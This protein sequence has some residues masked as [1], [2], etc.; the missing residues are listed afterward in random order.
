MMVIITN[1]SLL[2]EKFLIWTMRWLWTDSFRKLFCITHPSP[3]RCAWDAASCCFPTLDCMGVIYSE[4]I[5]TSATRKDITAALFLFVPWS[6][7][8]FLTRLA[9]SWF[10]VLRLHL[11]YAIGFEQMSC[12]FDHTIQPEYSNMYKR[13]MDEN[14]NTPHKPQFNSTTSGSGLEKDQEICVWFLIIS[15]HFYFRVSKERA[16]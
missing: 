13:A 15:W 10:S 12:R 9:G 5:F 6:R 16:T 3:M 14:K 11:D 8:C 1:L 7:G 2:K 4:L